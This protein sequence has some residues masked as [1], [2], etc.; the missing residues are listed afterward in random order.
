[1]K[2]WSVFQVPALNLLVSNN[3]WNKKKN[4]QHVWD[5]C[6]FCSGVA[7]GELCSGN[8]QKSAVTPPHL[9]GLAGIIPET[10][11]GRGS[12]RATTQARSVN[13]QSFTFMIPGFFPNKEFFHNVGWVFFVLVFFDV[14]NICLL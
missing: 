12:G 14:D 2:K 8:N 10:H 5:C 13:S 1:M 11:M 3:R 4:P 6:V 9:E 7:E